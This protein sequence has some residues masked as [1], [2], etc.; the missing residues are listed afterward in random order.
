MRNILFVGFMVSLVGCASIFE[1]PFQYDAPGYEHA[2]QLA[3]VAQD[4]KYRAAKAGQYF[5]CSD[6][7]Q[8][9]MNACPGC[10]IEVVD[11]LG[12]NL[13]PTGVTHA[14]TVTPQ[15]WVIDIQYPTPYEY[16][17]GT[18]LLRN[19]MKTGEGDI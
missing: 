7:A 2:A 19:Y 15:N 9:A 4:A 3:R 14:F 13:L 8:A 1:K 6:Y 10:R 12:A 16:D 18:L 5:D 17:D 11:M